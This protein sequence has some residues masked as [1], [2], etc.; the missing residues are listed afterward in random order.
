MSELD[1]N[2]ENYK[3]YDL[4]TLFDLEPQNSVE[5]AKIK[6]N[7]F[8]E[9]LQ[10]ED[11]AIVDFIKK[12]QTKLLETHNL[13]IKQGNKNPI[14]RELHYKYLC[15]DSRFRQNNSTISNQSTIDTASFDEIVLSNNE[16]TNYVINLSETLKNVVRMKLCLASIPFTW[17]NVYEPK[18]KF[19]VT[20]EGE[21]P[22]TISL[23]PGHYT[24]NSD[25]T[26]PKNIITVLNNTLVA[27]GV[28]G[29]FSLNIINGKIDFTNYETD[30]LTLNF[31]VDNV[32]GCNSN[33]KID[34]HFGTILGLKKIAYSISPSERIVSEGFPNMVRTK[35]LII[36][37][38]DFNKNV[39]ANK[40]I[41]AR[42]RDD[43][44]SLPKYYNPLVT[45]NA[46]GIIPD[47]DLNGTCVND[48]VKYNGI[49]Q[50]HKLIPF[51]NETYNQQITQK[52]LYSL[53]E[54]IKSKSNNKQVKQ[55][56]TSSPNFFAYIPLSKY[57]LDNFGNVNVHD[58]DTS[59]FNERVYYGP[60]NI[61]RLEVK[62][63][64]DNGEVIDFNGSEWTLTLKI[65]QLYQY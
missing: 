50:N 56:F 8:I 60:V 20:K 23:D 46:D 32:I 1:T 35:Y 2:L 38:N 16:T 65:E 4:M 25:A 59:D 15:L 12:A 19:N 44:L 48:V 30:V 41:H 57:D 9:A 58:Y 14:K 13:A 26:D 36:E 3:Y 31:I 18:N 21:N 64:D 11:Q 49:Q 5:D 10:G 17:Y 22:I 53:N 29:V 45:Q 55:E 63:L 40:F 7:D 43:A 33:F 24:L 54:I 6:S 61:E 34:N 37:L 27:K 47:A 39:I 51:Y 42:N 62:V 28:A 52:Q